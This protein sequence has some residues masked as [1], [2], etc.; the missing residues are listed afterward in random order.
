M[1][2]GTGAQNVAN[3]IRA[4]MTWQNTR[5]VIQDGNRLNVCF[6]ANDLQQ[7]EVLQYTSEI[8]VETNR[9]HATCVTRHLVFLEI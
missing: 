4:A 5:E 6:A 3:V 2:A 9:T 8:T 7:L 1:R